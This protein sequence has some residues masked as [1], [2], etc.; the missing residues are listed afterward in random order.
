MP[1]AL[2][3]VFICCLLW[4][5]NLVLDNIYL[6]SGLS[7]C[8]WTHIVYIFSE[9]YTITIC[10]HICY[11]ERTANIKMAARGCLSAY[12]YVVVILLQGAFLSNDCT[13]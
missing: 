9:N 5:N 13:L 6:N 8:C 11:A 2:H 1:Q 12:V 10:F 3:P 4:F 7:T